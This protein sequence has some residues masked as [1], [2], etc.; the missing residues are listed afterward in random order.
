MLTD[1]AGREKQKLRKQIIQRRGWMITRLK[2]IA[3]VKHKRY[4]VL[5]CRCSER[6]IRVLIA[7]CSFRGAFKNKSMPIVLKYK[8]QSVERVMDMV[9][10]HL[11]L[12]V[13]NRPMDSLERERITHIKEVER[14]Q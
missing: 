8:N 6:E 10:K 3:K 14:C 4:A 9:M 12:L 1:G 13:L 5:V 2:K 7:R 11:D